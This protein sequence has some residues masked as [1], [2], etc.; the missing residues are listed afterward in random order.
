M[1]AADISSLMDRTTLALGGAPEFSMVLLNEAS[2]FPHG[3]VKPQKV[4]EGSVI[5]MD[6]GCA[7]HGYQSNLAAPGCSARQVP[8]N[9]RCGIP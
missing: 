4:R 7:L 2:A 9:A 8:D 5:L 3:S 1:S 6:C